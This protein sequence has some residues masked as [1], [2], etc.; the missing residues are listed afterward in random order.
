MRCVHVLFV[1]TRGEGRKGKLKGRTL[2]IVEKLR[3]LEEERQRLESQINSARMRE[4]RRK[5]IEYYQPRDGG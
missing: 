5:G 3:K 2:K 1:A 4:L